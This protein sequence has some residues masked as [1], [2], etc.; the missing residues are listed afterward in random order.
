MKNGNEIA[1]RG[2]LIGM[3]SGYF[4]VYSY[5]FVNFGYQNCE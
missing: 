4:Y 5:K 2:R 1:E 3:S